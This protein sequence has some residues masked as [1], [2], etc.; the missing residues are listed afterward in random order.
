M[1]RSGSPHT[2]LSERLLRAS[3]AS[4]AM[5]DGVELD[6][7]R[8]ADEDDVAKN[9]HARIKE[10]LLRLMRGRLECGLVRCQRATG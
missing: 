3:E 2:V 10:C 7:R 4:V 6:T 8:R 9:E 1:D 5:S